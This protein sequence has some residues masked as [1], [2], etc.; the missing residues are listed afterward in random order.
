MDSFWTSHPSRLPNIPTIPTSS[1]HCSSICKYS[2]HSSIPRLGKGK[3]LLLI[4]RTASCSIST[5]RSAESERDH[6][7]S[8]TSL[9]FN[10]HSSES[11]SFHV[12]RYHW[13]MGSKDAAARGWNF[14]PGNNSWSDGRR[15]RGADSISVE[16]R[17]G[18]S[19]TWHGGKRDE[20][21][22]IRLGYESN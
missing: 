7:G 14:F 16:F 12:A 6:R 10:K 11:R 20:P 15:G 4:V 17:S 13:T 8:P 9:V 1:F 19:D 3:E 2:T 18:N 22:R 21:A 5:R